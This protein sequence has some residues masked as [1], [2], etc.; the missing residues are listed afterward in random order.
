MP[1]RFSER[2]PV[3]YVLLLWLLSVAC[4]VLGGVVQETAQLGGVSGGL[5][6]TGLLALISLAILGRTNGWRQIG[7]TAPMPAGGWVH[8]AL[9]AAWM[10]ANLWINGVEWADL[11][12]GL[13]LLAL[14]ALSGYVEE[15]YYRGIMLRTLLPKGRGW[16]IGLTVA[17]FSLTHILHALNGR[18]P[19]ASLLQVGYAAAIGLLFTAIWLRTR[20][21]WPLVLAHGINNLIAFLASSGPSTGGPSTGDLILSA[22]VVI[23]SVAY[24]TYL[25]REPRPAGTAA[26]L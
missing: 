25:L 12:T 17:L 26:A 3:L 22:F 2:Y 6:A 23:G 15:V 5:I 10:A 13:S 20:A 11:A 7:L 19:M 4:Y 18:D 14:A 24:G 16:A 9:P 1:K 21:L 8:Y